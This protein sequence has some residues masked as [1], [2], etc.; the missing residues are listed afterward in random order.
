[1]T[2]LRQSLIQ[3]FTDLANLESQKGR[4]YPSKAFKDVAYA[5]YKVNR[6][7]IAEK[8]SIYNS[9]TGYSKI[10]GHSSSAVFIEYVKYGTCSRLESDPIYSSDLDKVTGIGQ[11]KKSI[12]IQAG[13]YNSS[14]L[15]KLDLNVNQIIPGTSIKFTQQMSVGL[16]LW[17]KTHGVRITRKQADKY[18]SSFRKC[19]TKDF[20]VLGS[21]RRGNSTIGDID[22]VIV[23]DEIDYSNN[24]INWLDEVLV[25]GTTKI[26][27]IKG[28]TQV[29]VRIIDKQFLGAHLL[30]G[31]GSQEF[32]I[33]MRAYAKSIGMRLNEYGIIDNEGVFHSFDKEDEVFK[34]LGLDYVPP[35]RR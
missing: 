10:L 29:D 24:I 8:V 17:S 7:K 22:I 35:D 12:L 14:D 4:V 31:T 11:V 1:M 26:A 28:K 9:D 34:F 33:K 32:N 6:Y 15:L 27:G 25:H 21:Y 19:V 5:L 23:N 20:Y 16:K 13:I 18:I 3:I 30:H 2:K